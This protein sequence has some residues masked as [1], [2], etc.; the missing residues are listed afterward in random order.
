MPKVH[1]IRED[2]QIDVPSDTDL[3]TFSRGAGVQLYS[4]AARFP[5]WLSA[6]LN[7]I[8]NCR[9]H[10]LCGTCVVQVDDP[11]A[12]TPRSIQE[13]LTLG[14]AC[15]PEYRLACQT[16][17]TGDVRILTQPQPPLGWHVHPAYK[18]MAGPNPFEGMAPLGQENQAADQAEGL[19]DLDAPA[20]TGAAAPPEETASADA[21]A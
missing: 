10:G 18:N 9:G 14:G 2:K 11:D 12:M 5:L 21:P 3:R 8:G 4:P 13:E 6:P 7:M 17:V 1:F 15:P 20:A 16:K 19:A